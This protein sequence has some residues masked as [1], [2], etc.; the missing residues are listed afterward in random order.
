MEKTEGSKFNAASM[1]SG[2]IL[3]EVCLQLVQVASCIVCTLAGLL[4]VDNS[5]VYAL[6]T[7]CCVSC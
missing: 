5:H 7:L 2:S 1:P 6:A 3:L 4:V